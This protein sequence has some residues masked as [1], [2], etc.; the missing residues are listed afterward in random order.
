[1]LGD[2]SQIQL[3]ALVASGLYLNG[4][5]TRVF[6][7]GSRKNDCPVQGDQMSL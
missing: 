5:K 3:V 1:M 2:F 6:K 4:V 7:I